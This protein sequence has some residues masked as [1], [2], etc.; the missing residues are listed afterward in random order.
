MPE[1]ALCGC[2]G[3]SAH[4]SREAGTASCR[5]GRLAASPGRRGGRSGRP[6]V[7]TRQR[8][9]TMAVAHHCPS[10]L[11]V[12]PDTP[13]SGPGDSRAGDRSRGSSLSSSSPLLK[14]GETS[15]L[16][17]NPQETGAR[18]PG[19][20]HTAP[21]A[22]PQSRCP[23]RKGRQDPRRPEKPARGARDT[24]PVRPP[25]FSCGWFAPRDS[26]LSPDLPPQSLFGDPNAVMHTLWPDPQ[27]RLASPC[28]W[29]VSSKGW[30]LSFQSSPRPRPAPLRSSPGG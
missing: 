9:Q 27:G 25:F 6:L 5:P 7:L 26:A 21:H 2:V 30:L 16:A 17:F 15:T 11:T 23:A 12:P 18:G 3:V 20:S 29:A 4:G 1:C 22:H 10:S 28:P 13:S 14:K 19:G 24:W 8:P